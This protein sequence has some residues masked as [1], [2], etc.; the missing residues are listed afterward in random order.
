MTNKRPGRDEPVL[1]IQ[2]H[3][4]SLRW[5]VRY[6][7]L[8]RRQARLW[9]VGLIAFALFVVANLAML[10]SVVKGRWRAREYR[11]LLRE[12][13]LEGQRVQALNQELQALGEQA[14]ELL[15]RMERIYLTYGMPSD[16]SIGQGGF[17]FEQTEALESIYAIAV[18]HGRN[19]ERRIAQDLA[20][21]ET[22]VGE[23]ESFEEAHRD[24]VH[25][26]PSISP[27]RSESFVLTS[28][29][30]RR[31]SPFTK[32]IDM[33]PGLDLAAKVGTPVMA[34]ADG[35]VVFAGRYPIRQSVAWWRYG[36]MVAIRHGER[37]ITIFGHCDEVRVGNG[38]SVEQRQ[39]VATVGN[40]GWSTSP[41]LHYEV[42]RR[43]E[44][45]GFAPVD[46]RV[47]ILDHRWRD[48]EQLLIR[49]R[50]APDLASYEPLPSL[51]RR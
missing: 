38:E 42:R 44:D 21:L 9:A 35:T 31:R 25:T 5:G 7:F 18:R 26:T 24:Q 49:G 27:L 19:L 20:V 12:R 16:Q 34:P 28:P 43:E 32:Q 2:I 51:L 39:V 10:P 11:S 14:G 29:F 47:Y 15:V 3:P 36:N 33:H 46:P 17:P 22:F 37:F 13:S 23:V 8:G 45:G 30:G 48:E 6:L 50:R 1:E 40:T 4:G 41:H